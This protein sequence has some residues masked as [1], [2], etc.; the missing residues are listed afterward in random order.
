MWYYQYHHGLEK[1]S[2]Q[3]WQNVILSISPWP[4]EVQPTTMAEC[5]TTNIT[6]AL[7]S[8]ANNNGRM[9]YYQYHHGLEKCSQQQWQNV[10]LSISPWPW[11]VQPG[12][13]VWTCAPHV[14]KHWVMWLLTLWLGHWGVTGVAAHC[15]QLLSIGFTQVIGHITPAM[16]PAELFYMGIQDNNTALTMERLF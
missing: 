11:E 6:M 8:A 15:S 1:C 12:K 16:W 2:Q 5:D 13:Q 7:R 14:C 10:I 3:Q 4:W 9:W